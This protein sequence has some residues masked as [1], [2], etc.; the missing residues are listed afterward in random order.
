MK[1]IGSH[2]EYEDERNRELVRAVTE[3]M[4]TGSGYMQLKDACRLAV[5]SPCSRFWVSEERAAIVMSQL[6]KGEDIDKIIRSPTKREM[7]LEIFSRVKTIL[8]KH[9]GMSIYDATF[10]VVTERAPKFYLTPASAKVI[11]YR[12]Q[13]KWYEKKGRKY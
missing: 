10:D 4:T 9:P 2:F 1:Y 8:A 11:Y 12:I 7:Y 5:L 6:S 3:Q 13:S